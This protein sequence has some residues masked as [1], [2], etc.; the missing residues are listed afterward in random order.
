MNT[1]TIKHIDYGEGMDEAIIPLCDVLNSMKGIRTVESCEGHGRNVTEVF[2]HAADWTSL[3]K[4]ARAVDCRY[5]GLERPWTLE[6]VT[7]DAPEF[8][9]VP[10]MVFYLHSRKPYADAERG[11][12]TRDMRRMVLN[13]QF[14][15]IPFFEFY[16]SHPNEPEP[17]KAAMT[18]E[19]YAEYRREWAEI[20][21]AK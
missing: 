8:D 18:D 9:D 21:S 20:E 2:F 1:M 12:L 5:G 6:C 4:I 19:E 3:A 15:H 16:F 14:S 10:P 7:T 11:S 17:P 13:L